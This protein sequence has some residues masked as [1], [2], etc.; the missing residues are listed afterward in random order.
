MTLSDAANAGQPRLRRP[1]WS[2]STAYI[3][4]DLLPG[5]MRGP[6]L[7]LFDR[8]CQEAIGEPTPQTILGLDDETDDYVAYDGPTDVADK[9]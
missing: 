8:H 3:R 2:S 4:L 7:H 5:G 1:C 9:A 6:W